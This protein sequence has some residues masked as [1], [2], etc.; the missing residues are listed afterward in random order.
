MERTLKQLRQ[1]QLIHNIYCPTV[2]QTIATCESQFVMLHEQQNAYFEVPFEQFDDVYRHF[3]QNDAIKKGAFT[4]MQVCHT[5]RTGNIHQLKISQEGRIYFADGSIGLSTAISFAQSKWNG[6]TREE[7]VENAVLTGLTIIGEAFAEEVITIQIKHA[8]VAEHIK[9]D[10]GL[11]EAVQKNAVKATVKEMATKVTKKANSIVAKKVSVLMNKNLLIGGLVTNLMSSVDIVRTIKEE[12]AP[13]KLFKNVSKTVASV[14]SSHIGESLL[15]N[16]VA[17]KMLDFFIKEDEVE[18]LEIFNEE[19]AVAA[20]TFLLN[21]QELK[22]ALNDFNVVYNLDDELRK[23]YMADDRA[24]YAKSLIENE[25]S[26]IVK[27]RM[28]LQV[29]TN[30]ELYKVIERIYITID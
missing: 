2:E 4:Y 8:N 3:H 5:A 12:M 26:R 18:M 27:Y 14:A 10:D 9:L 11:K 30:E 19:L 24:A 13:G 21:E 6:A 17:K 28:Y 23:M 22:Q 1:G 7:A 15:T 25:L 16:K 29:P 20:E